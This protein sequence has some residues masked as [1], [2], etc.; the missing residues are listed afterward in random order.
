MVSA[1]DDRTGCG[2]ADDDLDGVHESAAESLM[3]HLVRCV[4]Q[5]KT[6]RPPTACVVYINW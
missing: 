1:D 4:R 5:A 2:D 6:C 3:L